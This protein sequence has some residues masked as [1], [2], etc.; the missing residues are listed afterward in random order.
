MEISEY[1]NEILRHGDFSIYPVEPIIRHG[2]NVCVEPVQGESALFG[3]TAE[4]IRDWQRK[5]YETIAV[6]CRDEEEAE[7]VAERLAEDVP[8]KNGAKGEAEEFGDGVMVHPESTTKGLEFDAVVLFDPSEKKYPADNGQVK[9][10]YVAATRALHEL[11]IL[12]RG[13]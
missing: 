9:L 10:L 7:R 4:T 8:V 3:R 12:H 1:A 11:T 13:E 2:A 5:G 6:I